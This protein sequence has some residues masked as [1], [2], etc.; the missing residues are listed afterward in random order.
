L[1]ENSKSATTAYLAELRKM[2]ILPQPLGLISDKGKGKH[3]EV[4]AFNKNLGKNYA[5][6]LSK[7]M[8]T[9]TNT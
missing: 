2:P 4:I 1:P 3:N 7:S 9:L 5:L 8:R 6:C